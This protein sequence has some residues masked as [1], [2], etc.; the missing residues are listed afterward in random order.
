VQY[1]GGRGGERRAAS[2]SAKGEDVRYKMMHITNDER[3]E[4]NMTFSDSELFQFGR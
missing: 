3:E 1:K 4:L 2:F